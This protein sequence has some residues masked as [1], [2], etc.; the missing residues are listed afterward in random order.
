RP[1]PSLPNPD[2][3]SGQQYTWENWEASIKAK[4]R[5]DGPAIGG[6]EAQFYYVYDRLEGKIQ[7]LVMPQLV[8][9]EETKIYNVDD[10][11][12]QLSRLYD[13]PNKVR[14]AE[15]ALHGLRQ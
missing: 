12:K 14:E 1:K 15:D 10:L 13:D 4:I 9:A 5:I 7:S 8:Q 11:F 2:K 6:P 3:F